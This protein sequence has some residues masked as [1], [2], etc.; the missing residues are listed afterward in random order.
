MI[1]HSKFA[2]IYTCESSSCYFILH[3]YTNDIYRL[4]VH[5][6]Q[7]LSQWDKSGRSVTSSTVS[8]WGVS[9]GE[10]TQVVTNHLWLDFNSVENLTVVNTNN[11]TDHFWDND[12]VSQV[13]L[14]NGWLFVWLSSKLSSSQLLDET[15]WLGV[16]TSGESSS[17]SST[18]Q[19]GEFFVVQ[20]NELGKVNTLEGEGLE[21]SLSFVSC[22]LVYGW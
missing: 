13:S 20:A 16:K 8:D 15:H 3:S 21:D 5:S 4:T 18:A 14:N 6:T 12:H 1:I 10:F 17:D 2:S 11:R 19:L 22:L 9:D 7:N